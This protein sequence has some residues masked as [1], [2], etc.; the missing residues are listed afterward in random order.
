MARPRKMSFGDDH[1]KQEETNPPRAILKEQADLWQAEDGIPK[2]KGRQGF[3]MV[4]CL[5]AATNKRAYTKNTVVSL[6]LLSEKE[7]HNCDKKLG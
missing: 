3:K 6:G 1:R 5:K 7:V 4:S 2:A